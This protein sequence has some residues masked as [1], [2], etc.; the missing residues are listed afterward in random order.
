MVSSERIDVL[1]KQR[2]DMAQ[3]FVVDLM[4]LGPQLANE[5]LDL[6]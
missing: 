3:C 6:N 4:P 1:P 2:R 5:L